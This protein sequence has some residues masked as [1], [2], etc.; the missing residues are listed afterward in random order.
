[1]EFACC[2]HSADFMKINNRQLEACPEAH[3]NGGVEIPT[4]T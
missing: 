2:Q 4:L 3:P 1:M